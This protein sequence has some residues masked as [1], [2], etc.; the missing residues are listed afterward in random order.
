MSFRSAV[1]R[2][3][4]LTPSPRGPVRARFDGAG[5]GRSLRGWTPAASHVNSMVAQGGARLL[6]RVRDLEVNNAHVAQAARMWPAYSIGTGIVPSLRIED[7]VQRGELDD[8]WWQWTDQAD[9]DDRS[10]FY[11]LQALIDREVF[12]GGEAFVLR[13][14]GFFG[15]APLALRVLGSEML[16][17]DAVGIAEGDNVIRSGIEFDGRGRRVAYHFYGTHP[18]D[19][20]EFS[21]LN[22]PRVR[23]A[24][25]DVIHTFEAMQAGQIRGV[26]KVAAAVVRLHLGSRFDEAELERQRTGALFTGFVERSV[27]TLP[28]ETVASIFSATG[29]ESYDQPELMPGAINDLNPGETM[30]FSDPPQLAGAFEAFQ[31]R[32]LTAIAAAMGLPY[33]TLTNDPTKANFGS[34]RS[35]QLDYK[36]RIE[37]Y[38]HAV[39]VQ[40]VCRRVRQWWERSAVLAGSV[41][42][43][44]FGIIDWMPPAW[45]WI[46]PLKDAKAEEQR[47]KNKS[48]SERQVQEQGGIPITADISQQ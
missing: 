6:A 45:D 15:D 10:D 11:G 17:L 39:P 2:A 33:H 38:Q 7:P 32:N 44:V 40:Q 18:G 21:R 20:T 43:D 37:M 22:I 28:D 35:V 3:F 12:I 16:P 25:H 48:V 31:F 9:F 47:L 26:S 1:S 13:E 4:G 24:A 36:R 14:A 23:V 8:L 30:K 27:D 41:K 5:M 46:D 42:P 34:T 19:M 29:D